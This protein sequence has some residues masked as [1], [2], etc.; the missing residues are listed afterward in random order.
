MQRQF[1]PLNRRRRKPRRGYGNQWRR[2]R[3]VSVCTRSKRKTTWAT[4][5]NLGSHIPSAWQS[6]SKGQRSRSRGYQMRSRRRFA[7]RYECLHDDD[8]DDDGENAVKLC[9]QK[10]AEPIMYRL[11]EFPHFRRTERQPT[12]IISRLISLLSVSFHV[13]IYCF[14]SRPDLSDGSCRAALF[15]SI[16]FPTYLRTYW[17]TYH[18]IANFDLWPWPSTLIWIGSW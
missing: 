6:G 16:S 5:T 4:N 17:L 3:C 14:Q 15:S 1:I 7:C 9:A 13:N 2:Q 8:D 10:N 12:Q 18:V 11:L